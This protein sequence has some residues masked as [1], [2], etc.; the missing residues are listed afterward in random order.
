M[1]IN[2]ILVRNHSNTL[3]RGNYHRLTAEEREKWENL[4]EIYEL[5]RRY[6]KDTVESCWLRDVVAELLAW[7]VAVHRR[8]GIE[9]CDGILAGLE[10]EKVTLLGEGD[11]VYEVVLGVV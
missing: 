10:R 4:F 2:S 1:A 9:G 3:N 8:W 11:Y 7:M 5:W 6:G